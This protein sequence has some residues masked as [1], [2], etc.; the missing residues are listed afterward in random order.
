[1]ILPLHNVG[2]VQQT[3]D[4][5]HYTSILGTFTEHLPTIMINNKNKINNNNVNTLRQ[6]RRAHTRANAPLSHILQR[7]PRCTG[8]RSPNETISRSTAGVPPPLPPPPQVLRTPPCYQGC[9]VRET[10]PQRTKVRKRQQRQRRQRRPTAHRGLR[11]RLT[12]ITAQT[13]ELY[14]LRQAS[15]TFTHTVASQSK[16]TLAPSCGGCARRFAQQGALLFMDSSGWPRRHKRMLKFPVHARNT[17]SLS[18]VETRK[19]IS[20]MSNIFT[21]KL[22][23][24]SSSS[25]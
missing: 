19:P 10:R 23:F 3:P 20:E 16:A 21:H 24:L 14:L 4:Q 6:H 5:P 9:G 2:D 1:M 22:P 18:P 12:A 17:T 25:S 8:R 15:H 11:Q 13:L 7:N